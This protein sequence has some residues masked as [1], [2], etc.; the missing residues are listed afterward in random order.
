MEVRH[1][2]RA[3]LRHWG[4]TGKVEGPQETNKAQTKPPEEDDSADP[5]KPEGIAAYSVEVHDEKPQMVSWRKEFKLLGQI[6]EPEQKDK[7]T[8]SSVA[9]QIEAGLRKG[10]PEEEVVEAVIRSISPGHRLRSYLEGR[11]DLRLDTVRRIIRSH[12]REK[13]ATSLFQELSTSAQ[14]PKESAHDFVL[15]SLDLKQKVLFASREARIW[16]RVRPASNTEAV[17]AVYPNW[18]AK[19]VPAAHSTTILGG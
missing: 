7:L 8:F 9:R 16:C 10:Y 19:R 11:P 17:P 1:Y 6:G 13:D 14:S 3:W 5:T 4:V 15:R 18:P 12:Y 2:G